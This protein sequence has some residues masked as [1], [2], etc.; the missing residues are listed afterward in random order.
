MCWAS[1]IPDTPFKN[2]KFEGS[3]PTLLFYVIYESAEQVA[4]YSYVLENKDLC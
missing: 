4:F 1:S 2:Y 3:F